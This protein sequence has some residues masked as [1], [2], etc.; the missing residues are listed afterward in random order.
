MHGTS[1]RGRVEP[2]L[3]QPLPP[4][5]WAR[6]D[7]KYRSPRLRVLVRMRLLRTA[8]LRA[9]DT[10]ALRSVKGS[11]QEGPLQKGPRQKVGLG[12]VPSRLT[13]SRPK[14]LGTLSFCFL[15]RTRGQKR[16]ASCNSGP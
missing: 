6:T 5:V 1:C 3:W 4:D 8:C 15:D 9:A 12:F 2:F 14:R 10:L 11:L 16:D 13:R 7:V